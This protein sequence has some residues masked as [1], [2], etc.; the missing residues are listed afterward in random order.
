MIYVPPGGEHEIRNTSDELLGVLFVNV[1]SGEG[2]ERLIQAQK[3][4]DKRP[5]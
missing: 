3:T 2:L 4:A 5:G 1:P